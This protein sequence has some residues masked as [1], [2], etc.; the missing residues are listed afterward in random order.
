MNFFSP[1]VSRKM[2]P[3]LYGQLYISNAL[4]VLAPEWAWP[5]PH[6]RVWVAAV[7]YMGLP[8]PLFRCWK[9]LMR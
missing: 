8:S 5:D 9:L 3:G 7:L 1:H 4:P 6:S 2:F